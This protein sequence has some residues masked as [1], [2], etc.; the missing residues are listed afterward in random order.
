MCNSTEEQCRNCTDE[1][2]ARKSYDETS[3]D[4][5]PALKRTKQSADIE[6]GSEP[7]K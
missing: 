6:I 4:T 7:Q 3:H 2:V 1:M 5:R